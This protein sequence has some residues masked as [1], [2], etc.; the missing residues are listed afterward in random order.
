MNIAVSPSLARPESLARLARALGDRVI[1][2][3]DPGYE[4]A[5]EVWNATVDRRP[6]AIVRPTSAADVSRAV[7]FARETGVDLAIRGGGHSMAGHGTVDD[8]IVLDM[9]RLQ[10]L[11]IDPS[12]RIARA[13]AG[14]LAGAYTKAAAGH[15][16]AT[17]FGATATVGVVGLTLGGGMG[18]LSRKHG[19]TV[20][21]LRSIELV[22]ADGD[23]V[24]A[25]PTEHPDLFWALRGGGGNF[26]VVTAL[27]FDLHPLGPIHGGLIALPLTR[28]VLRDYA[29][30]AATAADELTMIASA[31]RLPP[32][33]FVPQ[34]LV[35]TPALVVL[36][37]HA[38]GPHD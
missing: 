29:E 17:P 26:G 1:T 22:T 20:D 19:L 18:W 31:V 32:A 2:P 9:R 38:G 27:E 11:R 23:R 33:P 4:S 15:G 10:G 21:N 14:V 12:R 5:R 6:A 13:E 35:G 7:V 34:D 16:L 8:G 24:T 28:D 37:V 3:G 25:G 30:V 36:P